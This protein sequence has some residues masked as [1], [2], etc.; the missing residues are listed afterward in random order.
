MYLGKLLELAPTDEIFNSPKDP[1]TRQLLSAV[2]SLLQETP[3]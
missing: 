3:A 2:P 1:Y